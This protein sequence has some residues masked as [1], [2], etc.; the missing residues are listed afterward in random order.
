[1]GASWVAISLALSAVA[2][3]AVMVAC[4]FSC[5]TLRRRLETE[6]SSDAGYLHEAEIAVSRLAG[7]LDA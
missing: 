5:K 1:M 3:V 2:M 4:L 7:A 6:A